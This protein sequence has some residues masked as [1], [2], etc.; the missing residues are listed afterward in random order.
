[1]RGDDAFGFSFGHDNPQH[2]VGKLRHDRQPVF[3][4]RIGF[5]R[6]NACGAGH[7][8]LNPRWFKLTF[9]Q[10][11]QGVFRVIQVHLAA[12]SI[13]WIPSRGGCVGKSLASTRSDTY[14]AILTLWSAAV[15]EASAAAG[16]QTK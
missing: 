14:P 12:P 15:C 7:R 5:I 1:M 4:R 8:A 13:L 16:E 10:P 2:S 9:G 6:L 11:L 3:Q